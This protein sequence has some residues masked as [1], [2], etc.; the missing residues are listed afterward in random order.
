MPRSGAGSGADVADVGTG[1]GTET[2]A[3]A[4]VGDSGGESS[5]CWLNSWLGLSLV[6]RPIFDS[7]PAVPGAA[8]APPASPLSVLELISEWATVGAA[9]PISGILT[10][11]KQFQHFSY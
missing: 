10:F 7:D 8:G 2:G 9:G 3:V 1:T 4:G 11:R 6:N 5:C